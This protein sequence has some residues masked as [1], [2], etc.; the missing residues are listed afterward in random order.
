VALCFFGLANF[1]LMTAYLPQKDL[2]VFEEQQGKK[3]AGSVNRGNT[4]TD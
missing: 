3:P 2:L 4:K 1:A